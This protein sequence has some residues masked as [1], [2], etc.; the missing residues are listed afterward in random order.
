MIIEDPKI[1]DKINHHLPEDIRV[2]AI[3]RVNQG[4]NPKTICDGRIYEYFMP[5]YLFQRANCE[6]THDP[7]AFLSTDSWDVEQFCQSLAFDEDDPHQ[8]NDQLDNRSQPKLSNFIDDDDDDDV[9]DEEDEEGCVDESHSRPPR[10]TTGLA[11]SL[12]KEEDAEEV[13]SIDDHPS[14]VGSY[15]TISVVDKSTSTNLVIEYDDSI[16][17]GKRQK[18]LTSVA[19][20]LPSEEPIVDRSV[21][22]P[23]LP[24][25]NH[26]SNQKNLNGRDSNFQTDPNEL[27]GDDYGS[28]MSSYRISRSEFDRLGSL[29]NNYVGSH[30]FHNYTSRRTFEQQSSRR[31]IHSFTIGTP[32]LIDNLE[33]ISLK[34]QG[35]SF[36]LHQIRKMIGLAILLMRYG[37]PHLDSSI[38]GRSF[39]Q[40][41]WSI[42]KAPGIGLMLNQVLLDFYNRRFTGGRDGSLAQRIDLDEMRSSIDHF[43]QTHIYRRIVVEELHQRVFSQWIPSL[44][45]HLNREPTP[46]QP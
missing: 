11:E 14:G 21:R 18:S 39:L 5:T 17:P 44:V 23:L 43:K 32:Q 37:N 41:R 38:I 4:F 29:L 46:S 36:M 30:N 10:D 42:P 15:Q 34:V 6:A 40:T 33:W 25:D 1:L 22:E 19:I 3:R 28:S 8:L 45:F 13:K 9:D 26:S 12:P 24:N 7:A 20:N 2:F 31:V 27:F 16:R 35:Q